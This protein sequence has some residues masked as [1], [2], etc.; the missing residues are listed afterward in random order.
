[1]EGSPETD[2]SVPNQLESNESG[3]RSFGGYYVRGQHLAFVTGAGFGN[4]TRAAGWIGAGRGAKVGPKHQIGGALNNIRTR[5][6]GKIPFAMK[7]GCL[8]SS[9]STLGA[10]SPPRRLSRRRIL[11][12]SLLREG[13]EQPALVYLPE[14]RSDHP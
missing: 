8:A 4:E 7:E 13:G 12:E 14:S 2:Y 10:V 3:G 11:A 5:E 1:M 6:F 9:L